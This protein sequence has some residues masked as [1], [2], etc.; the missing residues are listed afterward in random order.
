MTE[1][2][3]DADRPF[4]GN[5]ETIF[6]EA[7]ARRLQRRLRVPVHDLADLRQDLLVDLI[8]GLPG[9]DARRGSIGLR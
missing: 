8:C 6:F 1:A 9:F 2:E 4:F 5:I 3:A 7:A